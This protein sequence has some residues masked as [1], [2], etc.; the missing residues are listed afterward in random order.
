MYYF[1]IKPYLTLPVTI[2]SNNKCAAY[3]DYS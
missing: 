1:E 2:L 3:H